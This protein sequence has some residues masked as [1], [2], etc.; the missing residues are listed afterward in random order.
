[1]SI[2]SDWLGYP[3]IES[4]RLYARV[5]ECMKREVLSKPSEVAKSLFK[6]DAVFKYADD[7]E[8]LMTLSGLKYK[9]RYEIPVW[10]IR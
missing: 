4:T 2:I 3:Y 8:M 7:D 1:M 6:G 5:T 10:E 9:C